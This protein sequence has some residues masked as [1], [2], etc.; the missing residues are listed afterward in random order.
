M[1]L[2]LSTVKADLGTELLVEARMGKEPVGHLDR[3]FS[4]SVSSSVRDTV[5]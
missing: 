1:A 5:G 2:D 3:F 4:G